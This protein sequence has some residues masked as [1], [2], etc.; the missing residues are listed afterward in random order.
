MASSSFN[1]KLSSTQTALAIVVPYSHSGDIDALRSVH[2]KAFR[3]WPPHLNILYPFVDPEHLESALK[4]LGQKL[5]EQPEKLQITLNDVDAFRHRYN[6]TIF[7]K[8]HDETQERLVRLRN[9]LVQGLGRRESEGTVDGEF[10]PHL[11][12][13]QV[14]LQENAVDALL[15]KAGRLEMLSWECTSLTVLKRKSSG[16]M[17]EIAELPLG[18][19]A[20]KM[21]RMKRNSTLDWE[22]WRGCFHLGLSPSNSSTLG[23]R[24][25]VETPASLQIS[26]WNL[27]AEPFAP[28][29]EERL[30]LIV[31]EI[32]KVTA[33]SKGYLK[34]LCLQEVNE[35]MLRLLLSDP[36]IK[37]TYPFSSHGVSSVLPSERNL[38][39][40]ASAPFMHHTLLFAEKHK[41]ALA[42]LFEDMDLVVANVHLTSGLTKESLAAR[43]GQMDALS[44]FFN[45]VTQLNQE[46][47]SVIVGDFNMATSSIS[48]QGA[49]DSKTITEDDL[50][51]FKDSIGTD[52][53]IDAF[54]VQTERV[55]FKENNSNLANGEHGATFDPINN[56]LAAM[57]PRSTDSRPQR[58][59]RI[60]IHCGLNA[61]AERFER[62]GLCNVNGTFASDHYGLSATL[63]YS[64]LSVNALRPEAPVT[65]AS[66]REIELV[67]DDANIDQFL[68]PFLPKEEDKHR[69]E[70]A[71]HQLECMLRSDA[72]LSDPPALLVPLGSYAMDTYFHDSD[73]DALVIG[74]LSP[75]TFFEFATA[76]LKLLSSHRSTADDTDTGLRAVHMINSLVPIIE[77]TLYGIK[78]DI[79]YCKAPE[80][81]REFHNLGFDRSITDLALDKLLISRLSP[82]SLRPLNTYRD[83]LFLLRSIPNAQAYRTAHR[84]LA[85]YLRNRG[86]YAAKFGYLGGIHLSL[87]LSHVV[88]ALTLSQKSIT[89]SPASLVRTFFQYY[90]E[91]DWGNR[92]VDNSEVAW[93]R[94]Y[95]RSSREAVVILALHRPTARENV[96]ES[97]TRLSAR[98]IKEEFRHAKEIL[99]RAGEQGWKWC[100]RGKEEVVG[101]F[102]SSRGGF[103]RVKVD[104]WGIED[105]KGGWE[106]AREVV[107]GIE[108]R[109]TALMVGFGKIVGFG[110]RAR[111]WPGKF[112][113]SREEKDDSAIN[114]WYL[115]AVSA[116]EGLSAE[117]KKV[118]Q[119]KVLGTARNFESELRASALLKD[120]QNCWVEVDIVSK[121]KIAEI[122]LVLDQ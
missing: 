79:Q 28:P 85:L 32:Q 11:S 92:I 47:D 86:L 81:L 24:S 73:I 1:F 14:S 54:D 116:K 12:I 110:L 103:V 9:V 105:K 65:K 51:D 59:D 93:H 97:C 2:D 115:V 61:N 98:V 120:V 44:G 34:V 74:S 63:R 4:I 75:K 101:E 5:R 111:L 13:G 118:L 38:L 29:F 17:E 36:F 68:L 56:A 35:A 31:A 114:R 96:A 40:F 119:E 67:H 102:L 84:F 72:R 37:R 122:G 45:A 99:E 39:T 80:L 25:Y 95:V 49:L 64:G 112:K 60:L 18:S 91:F 3:K 42:V 53:W 55:G 58:Y 87:M 52:T 71:I 6:A 43:T 107:G 10:R 62:F 70:A 16:D 100:L 69:R 108:S 104:V 20:L 94:T 90:A 48:I 21:A 7:M 113:I 46:I 83:T 27:M 15:E 50:F 41:T 121:K 89:S 22:Q 76:R 106:R 82:A 33:S 23:Y 19:N 57:S 8:P 30:P 117:Q 109:F 66:V 88:K 78:L 26:T 77:V